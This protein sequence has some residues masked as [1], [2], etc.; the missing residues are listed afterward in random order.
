MKTLSLIPKKVRNTY[1]IMKRS[2]SIEVHTPCYVNIDF[3]EDFKIVNTGTT[4][5]I[6]NDK[7]IVSVWKDVK[8]MHVT[9][10]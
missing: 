5:D 9:I 7:C 4:I 3:D 10:Y 2:G 8:N 6:K 1:Q